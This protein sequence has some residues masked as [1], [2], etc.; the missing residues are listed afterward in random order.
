M[1]EL[2]LNIAIVDT[3]GV[4]A[5]MDAYNTGLALALNAAGADVFI[6]SNFNFNHIQITTI[7]VFSKKAINF[8]SIPGYFL[9]FN[10]CV[11]SL[12]KNRIHAIV[13]HVFRNNFLSKYLHDKIQAT[14]IK[15]ISVIHDVQPLIGKSKFGFKNLTDNEAVIVHS[16]FAKECLMHESLDEKNILVYP[17]GN[18]LHHIN[19]S[20]PD[21][22]FV[23]L[24]PKGKKH[25]LLF[26]QIKESKGWKI[27][28]QSMKQLNN[29]HLIIA[30]KLRDVS[31]TQI[32]D[33]IK[34]N[35]LEEK[36][37]LIARHITESERD[38]IFNYADVVIIP[39]L[40]IYQS[41]VLLMAMSYGKCI[42]ASGLD[43]NK[44]IITDDINGKLFQSGNA[45]ALATTILSLDDVSIKRLGNNAFEL[46]QKE[47]SWEEMARGIINIAQR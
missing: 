19:Q 37:T 5:G 47:F 40:R 17:H 46:A 38:A 16:R 41:G 34:N 9:A 14:G 31:M 28:I 15:V 22:N 23:S 39:Y 36:V 35:Q 20:K 25:I 2:K 29:Y 8:L 26:G 7:P 13:I 4:K 32:T 33:E 44:E 30:G 11:H 6:Y 24:F 43:A 1:A 12:K 3:V 45:D 42:V 21:K 10:K 18:F 27:A